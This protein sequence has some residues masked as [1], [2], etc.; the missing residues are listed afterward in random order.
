MRDA[1]SGRIR[2]EEQRRL[3]LGLLIFD[4]SIAS[5]SVFI[6]FGSEASAGKTG[7]GERLK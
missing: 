7:M 1:R 4:E 2:G 6:G 5:P 3:M